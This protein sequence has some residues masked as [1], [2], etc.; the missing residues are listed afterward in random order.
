MH[1]LQWLTA[2]NSE[3]VSQCYAL[4]GRHYA[5]NDTADVPDSVELPA[6]SLIQEECNCMPRSVQ[7]QLRKKTYDFARADAVLTDLGVRNTW[8]GPSNKKGN[9]GNKGQKRQQ[10]EAAA[11]TTDVSQPANKRTCV[12]PEASQ[13]ASQAA[14]QAVE[15]AA[16]AAADAAAY[17]GAE[18]HAES[19]LHVPDTA[20]TPAGTANPSAQLNG[21]IP[22]NSALL[23]V[24]P[25]PESTPNAH[26]PTA[27]TPL[28]SAA[29]AALGSQPAQ[30]AD[31]LSAPQ[32]AQGL[33]RG[34]GQLPAGPADV[35]GHA[36]SSTHHV[37]GEAAKLYDVNR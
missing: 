3:S 28:A 24:P 16:N 9:P 14:P 20:A 21:H 5:L 2:C 6:A 30:G 13:A 25:G 34:S 27:Q 10:A 11:A 26:P 19:I 22:D 31:G 18:A 15:A 32:E 17:A 4:C 36:S 8:R 12:I 1:T 37:E 23:P 7:A 29:A 35:N 33:K